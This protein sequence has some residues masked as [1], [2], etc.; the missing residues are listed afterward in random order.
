MR[1][2]WFPSPALVVVTA[3]LFVALGDSAFAISSKP[4]P[5]TPCAN[6][7]VKGYVTYDLDHASGS[8]TSSFS[9]DPRWFKTRYN[10]RGGAPQIRSSSASTIEVRF[11]GLTIN[12]ATASVFSGQSTGAAIVNIVGADTVRLLFVDSIGSVVQ[13]GFSLIVT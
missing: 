3:A 12:A 8:L 9:S 11:P 6:G 2:H 5:L 13:R 10:C 7:T 1:S 4:R